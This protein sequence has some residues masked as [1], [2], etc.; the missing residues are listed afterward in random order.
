MVEKSRPNYF[1]VKFFT[2]KYSTSKFLLKKVFA[3]TIFVKMKIA[4]V[5]RKNKYEKISIANWNF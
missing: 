3:E 4:N 5:E 2:S 1:Y